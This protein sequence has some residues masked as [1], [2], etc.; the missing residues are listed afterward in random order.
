MDIFI[1]TI[2]N[3]IVFLFPKLFFSPSSNLNEWFFLVA[4]SNLGIINHL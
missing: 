3:K 2:E 1:I 4:R